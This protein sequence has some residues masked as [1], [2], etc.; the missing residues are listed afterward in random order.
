[1]KTA[2]FN[3]KIKD[4]LS[5]ITLTGAM[6][7]SACSDSADSAI[8]N[9]PAIHIQ[10]GQA[11][12]DMH[13]FKAAFNAASEAIKAAP[14][15]VDGYLILAAIHQQSGQPQNSIKVL[16]A[17]TG[18]KN[19]EYYFALLEAY[20][21]SG[22]FIS[23]Q[24]MIDQQRVLLSTQAPRLQ[25]AI[26]QQLFYNSQLAQAKTAFNELLKNS[27]FKIDSKLALAKIE[28][29]SGNA[30]GAINIIDEIIELD[31]TNTESIFLKSLIYINMGELD[32]AE[33]SLSLALTTLP[34][35]DIF[36]TQR[37]QIIQSLANVL[38][39]QGRVAEAMIYTHI[40]SDEF[41]G[42]ESLSLQYTR[43]LELFENQQFA[44]AKKLLFEILDSTPGHKKSA[45]LLGLILYKEG[46]P[47]NAGKYLADVIDPEISPLKL[48]ELYVA[49]QLQQNKSE[50]VLALLEYVP[51]ASRNAETWILYA[52]AAIQ[53]KEFSKA[54]TALDKAASLAPNSVGVALLE[55][56]YYNNLPDPQPEMALQSVSAA[57]AANPENQ[58]LQILHIRQLLSLNKKIEVNNY[59]A[60]LE[61][62]YSEST[63]TQLIVANYYIYQGKL[64]AAEKILKNIL[65]LENN[66]I[67]ALY[68][69]AKIDIIN[70]NWQLT[71][72]DYKK[73]ISFY[74]SE[75][76][77]YRGIVLA[78]IQL[79]QDP[80][81]AADYLPKNYEASVLALTLAN[82]TLQQNKIDLATG[83]A[84]E[85]ENELPQKYQA[86]LDE[87]ILRLNLAKASTAMVEKDYP[88]AR[89]ILMPAIK[90]ATKDIRLLSLLTRIE[91]ASG[92]YNEAQK[93]TEQISR[94]LPKSSLATQLNS[95][96]L[97]AQGKQ[98]QAINLL[99][100]YWQKTKDEGVAEQ[101]YQ[102]LKMGDSEKAV[103]FLNEWQKALP[104]SLAAQRYQAIYQQNKGNKQQALVIYET[105]LKR[106]PNDIISLNNAAWLY[107]EQGDERAAGLAEKAYRLMP[108][109]A[110]IADTYGWILFNQGD[111]KRGKTLIE[112]AIKLSPEDASI[113]DHFNIVNET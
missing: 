63:D 30:D 94:L 27:D 74:P 15:N 22:K 42:T 19:A 1:M 8:S 70:K 68:S 48:T 89:G 36:T 49:T 52:S 57:L 101:L 54:K 86:S 33:K 81:N 50:E 88:K 105:L 26:A 46:D 92:Q 65:A 12:L 44:A 24:K 20:Q 23:A 73:I 29:A 2:C 55:N 3:I 56:F 53:Q 71:L 47:K 62:T 14:A 109:N 25:L 80:L 9:D 75:I 59:V 64:D 113:N 61:K 108:N 4:I 31:A 21:K 79:Q 82:L 76:V 100:S 98:K 77:A 111:K 91:I 99:D 45:T 93:I 104:S 69:V 17:F 97:I 87:I 51:E 112:Q 106:A 38:T 7:L 18:T 58:K 103:T 16:E 83:Y 37:I 35:A 90:K 34:S 66:N 84:K 67:Q 40:L 96:I 13:Q 32:K 28:A 11:Y 43:A 85:A 95:D 5:A 60:S 72:T 10:Q 78:M 102:Q 39:Q 41:P 110:A 107:F 6:L